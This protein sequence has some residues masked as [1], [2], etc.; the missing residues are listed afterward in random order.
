MLLHA[1]HW[2]EAADTHLWPLAVRHAVFLYNSLPSNETGLSPNDLFTRTKH[3]SKRFSDLHPLFCP[4]YG[5]DKRIADRN[6]LPRWVPRSDRYIFVGF[7]ERHASSVPLLLNP[8]T[9]S[10]V[11]NDH[12]VFDDWFSTVP[13]SVD[14]LPAFGSDEWSKLFGDSTYQFVVEDVDASGFRPDES[15]NDDDHALA[16][17]TA[18]RSVA[19]AHAQDHHYESRN[20]DPVPSSTSNPTVQS[21]ATRQQRETVTQLPPLQREI[22]LRSATQ[23][24]G[25]KPNG[26]VVKP[27]GGASGEHG[28]MKPDGRVKP[29][30]P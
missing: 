17:T 20:P 19:I 21:H 18:S 13:T 14:R 5:L 8:R 4:A 7:C 16:A 9:G 10:I 23:C 11:S 24:G 26:K 28:G 25:M 27:D 29:L 3:P 6:K 2:P 1:V 30:Y 22:P 12:V 15:N